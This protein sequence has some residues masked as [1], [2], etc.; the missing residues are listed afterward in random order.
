M[1]N[2]ITTPRLWRNKAILFK[3]EGAGAYGI[4]TVPTG[5]T[6]WIEARNVSLTPLDTEKV[7]RNI[8]LPYLGNAGSIIVAEWAKLSFDVAMASSGAAG[9]A[10]KWS[11]LHMACGFA[12]TVTAATS[13]AYNLI[14]TDFSSVSAYINIDGTLH[15]MLGGRGEVKAKV[16]AKGTPMWN[17]SF[18]MLYIAPVTGAMPAVT[19]TGWVVEEGVNSSNTLPITINGTDMAFSNFEW[20]LGNKIARIDLPGQR[21]IAITGRTP[22]ASVTVLAPPL[23]DFDPFAL[24]KAATTVDVTT[25]HGV[26]A[27]K[28]IKHDLKTR[29]IGVDYDRIDEMLAYKLTLEPLPVAGNDEIA[30]TCL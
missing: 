29:V 17:Y 11:P 22:S 25:T 24:A 21:E 19:R 2:L 20:A 8:D 15:K 13:A 18:D 12:E 9:T 4:D 26:V 23:A 1:P 16:S 10:P 5:A 7:E 30:T 27:G 6:N 14:S 3:L 28:K